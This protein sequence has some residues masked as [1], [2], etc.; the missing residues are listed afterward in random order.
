MLWC[1]NCIC[2]YRSAS[3]GIV[4]LRLDG[5]RAETIFLPLAERMSPRDLAGATVQSTTG[6]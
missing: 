3:F 5:T 2:V 1:L 6:S 4:Q